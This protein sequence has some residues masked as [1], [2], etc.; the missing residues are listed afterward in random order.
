MKNA[1]FVVF[2]K[3]LNRF[4]GDK[5]LLFTTVILPGLI[6]FLMYTVMGQAMDSSLSTED[7][8]FNIAVANMPSGIEKFFESDRY[9]VTSVNANDID[10]V[11]EKISDKEYQLGIVFPE[12]FDEVLLNYR[13]ADS[14]KEVPNVQIYYNSSDIQSSNAY[15][16]TVSVLS[17]VEEE[18]SNVFDINH[19]DSTEDGNIYDVATDEE[20][21]GLLFAMIL[22]MILMT[23]MYS[24]CVS[25]SVESIAGEKERGTI[26][27]LLITPTPRNQIIIGKVLALSV[28]ALL[29]GLSSFLGTML[30]MP[31]L[32]GTMEDAVGGISAKYYLFTDYLW[33]I[34][35]IL[36]TI[37]LFVTL[38]SV[39]STFAKTVKEASSLVMPLMIVVMLVSFGSMYGTE[40]KSELY[41]YMI[42]VYNSVQ[43]MVGIFSFNAS[44]VNI[45]V[46]VLVNLLFTTV[47]LFALTKMFNSENIMFGK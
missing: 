42:P 46:T 15:G 10:S 6:I 2:K 26:A 13:G 40:A 27:S 7:S 31:M 25:F 8:T 38:I 29:G 28:M 12:D 47:G 33:L 35:V 43:S 32:V 44:P 22:P 41:W 14:Q 1:A 5:R 19:L 11:R 23:M 34:L 24:S 16:E 18:V 21:S 37:I 9:N 3:E 39:L 36:S 45:G 17:A 30:S 20:A 4:F